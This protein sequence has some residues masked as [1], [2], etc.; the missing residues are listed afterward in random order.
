LPTPE[1]VKEEKALL[2]KDEGA[3]LQAGEKKKEEASGAKGLKT[4]LL[5]Q[6]VE[7]KEASF[8]FTPFLPPPFLSW[9]NTC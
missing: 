7:E 9:G 3:T 6:A 2:T 8:S 5:E 1:Q 4:L